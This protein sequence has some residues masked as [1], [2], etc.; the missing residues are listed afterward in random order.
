MPSSGTSTTAAVV[1]M[2]TFGGKS[3]AEAARETGVYPRKVRN[4]YIRV[5]ERGF[6]PH[7]KP[8]LL[9]DEWFVDAP[10]SGRPKKQT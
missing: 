4:M 10:R 6:D 1:C 9:K 3:Y 7:A 8:L 2:I 5:I